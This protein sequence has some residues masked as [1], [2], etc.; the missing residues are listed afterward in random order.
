MFM[1]IPWDEVADTLESHIEDFPTYVS[2]L[3]GLAKRYSHGTRA[4]IVDR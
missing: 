1:K 4:K 2:P 3:L